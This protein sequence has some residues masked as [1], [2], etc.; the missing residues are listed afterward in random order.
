[1]MP[2]ANHQGRHHHMP[3]VQACVR[4]TEQ[5]NAPVPGLFHAVQVIG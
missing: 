5:Q 1:M 2:H 4:A 3:E